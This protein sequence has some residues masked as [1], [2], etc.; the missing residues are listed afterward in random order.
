MKYV[1]AILPTAG[2]VFLFWL[3]V[4]AMVTADRRERSAHARMVGHTGA[5]PKGTGTDGSDTR[6]NG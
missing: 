3:A 6:P 5:E 4:R 2:V 1:L